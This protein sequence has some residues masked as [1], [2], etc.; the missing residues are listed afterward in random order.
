MADFSYIARDD[1][2]NRKTGDIK[3]ENYNEA[4][5]SLQNDGLVVIK[6]SERDTSFDFIKPFINCLSLDVE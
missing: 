6:L 2:G 4:V 3:A 5:E 1:K